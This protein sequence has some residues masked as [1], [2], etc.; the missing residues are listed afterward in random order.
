MNILNDVYVKNLFKR[1]FF[2][3]IG[4]YLSAL[5]F[6]L[7]LKPVNLVA[8][9]TNGLTIVLSH[10]LD[11]STSKIIIFIHIVTL[12]LSL[13]FLGKNNFLG[14]LYASIIYP[15]FVNL[16]ENITSVITINYNDLFLITIFAGIISGL[17]AGLIYKND[18]SANGIGVIAPILHK[19]FK[20]PIGTANF[21][22]NTI[23]V[24]IGGY[25]FGLEMVLYAIILLG[26]NSYLCNNI[27]LG[28]S[29]NKALFIRSSKLEIINKYIYDNYYIDPT[30]IKARGGY[31]NEQGL[32]SLVV[33]SNLKYNLLKKELQSIDPNIFFVTCNSYELKNKDLLS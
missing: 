28:N 24:L 11:I 22:V 33:I 13:I 2:L 5:N 21:I 9:G 29:N 31:T 15:F 19:Y 7:L 14:L 25:Y 1:Y 16:T 10:L 3:T 4:L 27:I 30:V 26:I 17:S 8:G 20:L 32:M 12:I 18:F 6:N 23:I